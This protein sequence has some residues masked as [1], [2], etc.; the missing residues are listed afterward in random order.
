MRI[1]SRIIKACVCLALVCLGM[2]VAAAGLYARSDIIALMNAVDAHIDYQKNADA[3]RGDQFDGQCVSYVKN[4][5]FDLTAAGVG[6]NAKYWSKNAKRQGFVVSRM[7]RVGSVYVDTRGR[8]G[9]VGIVTGVKVVR[10]AQGKL[11]YKLTVRDSN[12]KSRLKMRNNVDYVSFPSAQHFQFIYKTE[13]EYYRL[14]N[15]ARNVIGG[16]YDAGLLA[17]SSGDGRIGVEF[18]QGDAELINLVVLLSTYQSQGVKNGLVDVLDKGF[19]KELQR[20]AH[21]GEIKAYIEQLLL[22]ASS[23]KLVQSIQASNIWMPANLKQNAEIRLVPASAQQTA[24]AEDPS[25]QDTLR[26]AD[27][28]ILQP[29]R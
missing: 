12:R 20:G 21:A 27:H 24:A 11:Q 29:I 2:P 8:Y 16:L 9:H 14:I 10:N 13:D 4:A 1:T 7:P 28:I 17:T 15:Q 22:G 18:Y 6:G 26:N 23:T 25:M 3:R 5:R 19:R